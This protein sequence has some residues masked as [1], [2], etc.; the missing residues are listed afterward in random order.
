[1]AALRI[2]DANANRAAEGVRTVEEFTRFGLEDGYLTG[3]CKET[4]HELTRV[5][6][7]LSRRELAAARETPTDVGT[8]IASDSEYRRQHLRDTAAAGTKRVEQALRSLEEYGKLL[9]EDFAREIERLRYGWYAVARAIEMRAF[10]GGRIDHVDLCVLIDGCDSSARFVALASSLV[11]AGA[12]ALQLR[13]KSLDDRALFERAVLLRDIT[14]KRGSLMIVNDRADLALLSDAD[15][16]HLGQEDL[17]VKQ[18]R[19]FLGPDR[20]IGVSTHSIEQV[21]CAVLDGADYIGCGPTFPSQ[22]KSFDTF[23]GLDFLRQVSEEVALPAF[24]IGGITLEQL[25]GVRETGCR[26]VAVSSAVTRA[27]DPAEATRQF[28]TRLKRRRGG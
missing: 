14:R 18:A 25:D 12:G 17:G 27:T 2:V 10:D 16:V 1:M 22:T 15:G 28:L 26:R 5:L 8:Q 7:M 24:A 13:D 3:K 11:E 20:L 9:S 4:R 19:S 21:R 6:A 23:P